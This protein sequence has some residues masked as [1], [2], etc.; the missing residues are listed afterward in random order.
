MVFLAVM[1]GGGLMS[2]RR[3]HVKLSC[4]LMRIV[5]HRISQIAHAIE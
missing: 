3:E 5:C 4:L 1:R 2:V